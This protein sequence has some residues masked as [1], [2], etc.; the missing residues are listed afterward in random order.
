[1][2]NKNAAPPAGDLAAL[3]ASLRAASDPWSR[4]KLVAFG[5]RTLAKLTPEQRLQ[6]MRQLGLQGAEQLAD[7]AAGGDA[8]TKDAVIEA[9]RALEADP[10]RLQQISAA[11]ADPRSRRETL[12]GLGAHVLEAVTAPP[13]SS[14]KRAGAAVQ[15][16]QPS[17]PTPPQPQPVPAPS[18]P[19][20]PTPS[21]PEPPQPAPPATP[22]VPPQPA[23]PPQPASP[24]QPTTPPPPTPTGEA[25][26]EPVA[27]PA[28]A[29]DES[30]ATPP[31]AFGS[32]AP[33]TAGAR[34]LDVLRELRSRLA[35]RDPLPDDFVEGLLDQRL[36]G[37]WARRRALSA[38]FAQRPPTD[39]DAALE[40]VDRLASPG[41]RR[42]VLGDLATSRVWSDEEWERLLAACRTA[43]DRRRLAGRRRSA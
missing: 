17:Q 38:L 30:P 39:V 26:V 29:L 8:K 20:A 11:I 4:V 25:V 7:V 3:L 19:P 24:P 21:T 1:M 14:P 5:A 6:L 34:A 9:L 13:P 22:S 33:S 37:D 16:S 41:S 18:T 42:W 36:R 10:R 2:A 31:I 28:A 32:S 35:G 23:T 40:L 27:R 15:P 12:V 43:A